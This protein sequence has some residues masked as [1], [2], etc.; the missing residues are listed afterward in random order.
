M[1]LRALWEELAL[2]RSC[3]A[4]S[5]VGP[6][7]RPMPLAL[8]TMVANRLAEP[9]SKLACYAYWMAVE[10]A[11]LPEAAALTL[12]HR[13]LALGFPRHPHRGHRA[14]ASSSALLILQR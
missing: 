7:V 1:W 6:V 5:R 2:A 10:R 11:Y 4:W 3:G 13:Y 12:D 9:W 14:R 8:F